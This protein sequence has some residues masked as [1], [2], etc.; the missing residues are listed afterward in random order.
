VRQIYAYN[1]ITA[2]PR[3]FNETD[4]LVGADV[5]PGFTA[6]VAGLFPPVTDVPEI[7]NDD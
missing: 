5:L 2:A 6:A 3:L 7:P 1:S 4:S